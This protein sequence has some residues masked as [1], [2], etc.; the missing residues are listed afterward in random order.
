[1]KN[2]FLILVDIVLLFMIFGCSANNATEVPTLTTTPIPTLTVAIPT[3]QPTL[4]EDDYKLKVVV[5]RTIIR[6]CP[7]PDCPVIESLFK[8]ESVEVI[9]T[10]GDPNDP[11]YKCNWGSKAYTTKSES[12]SGSGW[13]P[14]EVLEEPK[15]ELWENLKTVMPNPTPIPLTLGRIFTDGYTPLGVSV[16]INTGNLNSRNT[17]FD[18]KVPKECWDTPTDCPIF[19]PASGTIWE[20]YGVGNPKGSEGYAIGFLLDA[21]PKGIERVLQE[22]NIKPYSVTG[23]GT[24]VGHIIDLNPK[25]KP[26]D[27]IEKGDLLA[28]GVIDLPEPGIAQVL[29]IWYAGKQIQVSP[30]SVENEAP[31]CGV[32]YQYDDYCPETDM[33]FP[34]GGI[35]WWDENDPFWNT[36]VLSLIPGIS[37]DS[38]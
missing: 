37:Y 22:L 11:W 16:N 8:G 27:H 26:G 32:C 10:N 38:R 9:G 4:S 24:H 13:I 36:H 30:C 21:P 28:N 3:T 6:E 1:M 25:L 35:Q 14:A 2:F 33:N 15:V 34:N 23:Y 29:Y 31:Y 18:I 5:D 20:I 17:H 12:R 7:Q 19:S